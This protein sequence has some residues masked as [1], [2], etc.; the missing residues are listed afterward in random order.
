M[1]SPT[2]TPSWRELRQHQARLAAVHLGDLFAAEPDR[3]RR[4]VA[5]G[6]GIYADYSKQRV[7][8]ETLGLLLAL[9]RERGLAQWR[10]RMFAGEPINTSEARP[11]WHVA[12]RSATPPPEVAATLARM[13][14]LVD[15]AHRWA[16]RGASGRPLRTVINLG[17]GGSDLGP[18]LATHALRGFGAGRIHARFVANVDP[19]DLDAALEGLDPDTTL[20]VIASKTFTTVETLDNA[21]RARAWLVRTL[22]EAPDLAAHFIA[23]TA[24]RDAARAWGIAADRIFPMWDWVG[25]RYSVWSA[26]GLPLALVVGMTAFGE[27]LDGARAMDEHFR[28]APLASNLPVILGLLGV[29]YGDFCGAQTHAV[30]PY[31]A[32][33]REL[34]AYLQQLEMESNGKR[35]DRDGVP[36]DYATAPVVWGAAGTNGQ[37]AFHQLLHQGTLLVP[38]DFIVP[39]RPATGADPGAHRLLLANALAQS[40]ALAFGGGDP[41]APERRCPGNQPSTTIVLPRL[42]PRSLGALLALYEHKVFVQGVVWGINS[43]DQ[44]GV[45]LGKAM[46]KGLGAALDGGQAAAMDSSTRALIARIRAAGEAD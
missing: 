12:L 21:R 11:A 4:L 19:A 26:V 41:A 17:I 27:F 14:S 37:H 34:P 44:W 7:T 29:W 46:A 30:L 39:A 33:L 23:V 8:D 24:N 45:E 31:A 1:T 10:D 13:R 22:G 43:F 25:G 15:R 3:G 38:T 5:E 6:G 32:D 2:D 42:D 40:A 20:F 16:L 28:T 9:A 35:V 36:V 18:R